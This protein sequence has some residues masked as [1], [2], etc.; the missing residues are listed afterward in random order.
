MPFPVG[1]G[2]PHAVDEVFA[3]ISITPHPSLALLVPPSPAGE[4]SYLQ[5]V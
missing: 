4:G 3:I 5:P 1:E 2:G